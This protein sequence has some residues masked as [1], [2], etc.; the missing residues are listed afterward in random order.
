M[1]G[2][3]GLASRKDGA[4]HLSGKWWPMYLRF[5]VLGHLGIQTESE[6]APRRDMRFLEHCTTERPGC[7][8]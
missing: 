4:C 8:R 5:R 3:S 2:L 6:S 1:G 7:S